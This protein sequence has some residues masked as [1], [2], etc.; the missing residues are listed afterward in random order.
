MIPASRREPR[1]YFKTFKMI[2]DN[3]EVPQRKLGID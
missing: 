1:V 2:R 3:P